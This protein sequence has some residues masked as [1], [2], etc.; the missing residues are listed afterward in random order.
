MIYLGLVDFATDVAFPLSLIVFILGLFYQI[1]QYFV[2]PS[3]P[4]T[5]APRRDGGIINVLSIPVTKWV[6][7]AK[8]PFK[9][10]FWHMFASIF[11]FH[12]PLL[13]LIFLLPAHQVVYFG[14]FSFLRPIFKPFA[15]T[16][17]STESFIKSRSIWGPLGV[18]LNGD[19]LTFLVLAGSFMILGVRFAKHVLGEFKSDIG[20]Y[21]ALFLVITLVTFGYLAVHSQGTGLYE[22]YL[23]LH[24]LV[25]SFL[26]AYIPFS[27]FLHFVWTYWINL[28]VAFY[29]KYKKGV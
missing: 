1:S 9:H 4:K 15:I 16:Q 14:I 6:Q 23:A 7:V 24:I 18:I 25:A 19:V 26:I 27:K 5:Y 10:N 17:Q 2:V 28:L 13:A 12:L 22:T 29:R 8:I 11:L 21:F 20:D 3:P